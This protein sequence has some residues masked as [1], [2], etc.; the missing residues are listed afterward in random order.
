[1]VRDHWTSRGKVY[2]SPT[3]RAGIAILSQRFTSNGSAGPG[4]LS[5]YESST[6]AFGAQVGLGVYGTVGKYVI[7]GG[8]ASYTFAGA[9][10]LRYVLPSDGTAVQLA[11]QSHTIDGGVSAGVHFG[12]LGG[13]ALRLRIGGQMVLNL[14][15]PDVR[16]KLP[17]DRIIGMTIGLGLSAPA[18]FTLGGHPLGVSLYGGALAPAQR[19]QTVGLEDGAQ[20]TTFGGFFGGAISFTVD[21]AEPREVQGPARARGRLLVRVR[22][23]ALHRPVA[24]RQHDH[25]RRPRVGAAP[26]LARARLRLLGA[27][28]RGSGAAGPAR[29]RRSRSSARRSRHMRTTASLMVSP[30]SMMPR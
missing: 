1:M 2:L 15:Q 4:T 29:G 17:S 5:N 8:D 21:A 28:G 9:A 10:A 18:L 27:I 11:L 14:V 6:N 24:P 23:H 19:A 20:S 16:V 25:R 7:L 13:L 12:V 22:G 26:H 30:R 3:V